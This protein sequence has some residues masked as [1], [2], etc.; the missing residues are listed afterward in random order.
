MMLTL[1]GM[2]LPASSMTGTTSGFSTNQNGFW[3]GHPALTSPT[4]HHSTYSSIVH[5]TLTLIF[6][7]GILTDCPTHTVEITGAFLVTRSFCSWARGPHG[8]PWSI[9]RA[10]FS[11]SFSPSL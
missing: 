10:P 6:R 9:F 7:L 1:F 3:K 2:G 8:G 4:S 5:G 11:P